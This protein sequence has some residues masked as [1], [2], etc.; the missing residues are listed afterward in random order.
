MLRGASAAGRRIAKDSRFSRLRYYRLGMQS[1][2]IVCCEAIVDNILIV[3]NSLFGGGA[4]AEEYPPESAP[5]L[6][7]SEAIQ[8]MRAAAAVSVS[9]K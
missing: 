3:A 2:S 1:V 6:Q 9:G 5:S 7:V 4:G 8:T